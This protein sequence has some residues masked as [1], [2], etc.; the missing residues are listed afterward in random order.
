MKRT[1]I[2][3]DDNFG[4]S[5]EMNQGQLVEDIQGMLFLAGQISAERDDTAPFGIKLLFE[6]DQRQQLITILKKIDRL[7]EAAGMTRKNIL[8]LR[9][10]TVD[11]Q[12]FLEH[13]PIYMDWVKAVGIRPTNTL[14]GVKELALPGVLLEIE[15]QAA[16]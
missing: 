11:V 13:Y 14:I 7:L 1:A 4:A 3:L 16:R 9:I 6:G 15:V 2:N 8:H 5:I 10:F 12:G